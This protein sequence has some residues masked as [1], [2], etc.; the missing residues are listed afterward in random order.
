MIRVAG[1]GDLHF[2]RDSAGLLKPHLDGI[3]DEAD[4]LLVAGDLTTCGEPA[5]A[6][7]LAEE[8]RAV[9]VPVLAVLGN[10]DHHA[11]RPDDVRRVLED[12]GIRVLEGDGHVVEV[13]GSRVGVVGVKGF[14]GGFAGAC[15]TE[16]GEAETKRFV[17]HTKGLAASLEAGLAG[18]DADVRVALLHYAPVEETLHG[19]R[20]EI[21]PFLGSYLLGEA[22]DRGGADLCLHGHAHHG[23]EK[24]A[25][26]AG[27]PVRNVAQPL[28]RSAYKVYSLADG[29]REG[30]TEQRRP[31]PAGGPPPP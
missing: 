20:L 17:A 5:E 25:T 30:P 29:V 7:V 11:D 6:E 15:A 3:A 24:G 16:F 8:L 23:S 1:V 28:I 4:L 13:G 9:P 21:Y 2:G 12:A 19:E 14:G 22:V 10:H 31:V 18:L 27:V 26:P